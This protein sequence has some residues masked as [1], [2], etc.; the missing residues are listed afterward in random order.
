[1]CLTWLTIVDH[2]YESGINVYRGL[3]YLWTITKLESKVCAYLT[4]NCRL[5]VEMGLM[6]VAGLKYLWTI[7][8]LESR[9]CA[10]LAYNWKFISMLLVSEPLYRLNPTT[11]VD[12]VC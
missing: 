2:L 12:F 6:F 10:Y 9:A 5:V 1:M 3:K 7:T 4:Y 11:L 8:K